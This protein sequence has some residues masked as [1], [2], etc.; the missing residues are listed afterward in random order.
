MSGLPVSPLRYA[1]FL[2]ATLPRLAAAPLPG[3]GRFA[4][5]DAA[6]DAAPGGAVV[7][8]GVWRG[9]SLR[10]MAGRAPGRSF[11]GF[12]SLT[13]FPE[14]GRP[15]WRQDFRLRTPP[16]L[17][18]NCTLHIGGFGETVARF[19]ASQ[20][21]PLALVNVDCDIHSSS[22]IA[23][24]ALAAHLRPGTVIHLDEAVNYDTWLWN[25]M[26]ALFELLEATGLGIAWL[27]RAGRVRSLPETLAFLEA[28][29][30]PN[31]TDDVAAGF[32]R[33]AAGVLV[34]Q[35]TVLAL[36][37][38]APF[39]ARLGAVSAAHYA[40][41]QMRVDC[42]PWEP[43]LPPPPRGVARRRWLGAR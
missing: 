41:R 21:D 8:L 37:E 9:A 16:A 20:A 4:M 3:R 33:A 22:R 14:D 12:D 6:L 32:G 31:W 34:A 25:E 26:L 35:P 11:H 15:D 29:R 2:L 43:A 27:V 17:P 40:G 38:A 13:G 10:H 5:L 24:F 36:A 18:P 28:A 19:A 30:Y 7:E 39:A 1:A 23:L 42:D